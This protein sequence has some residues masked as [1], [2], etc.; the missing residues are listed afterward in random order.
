[1]A[2]LTNGSLLWIGEVRDAVS[3]ADLVIPSLD[4]GSEEAFLRVNRPHS[5]IIFKKVVEGSARSE[6]VSGVRYGWRF[7]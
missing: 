3:G 1:M 5:E 6:K 4:A 2:V 7:S